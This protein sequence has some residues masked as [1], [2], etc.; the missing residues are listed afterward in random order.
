MVPFDWLCFIVHD[1]V[2]PFTPNKTNVAHCNLLW[3][4]PKFPLKQSRNEAINRNKMCH[5]PCFRLTLKKYHWI[6]T[7][8]AL[9]GRVSAWK[10]L[11]AFHYYIRVT[12]T[13]K[14]WVHLAIRETAVEEIRS[15]PGMEGDIKFNYAWE[16]LVLSTSLSTNASF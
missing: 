4:V 6:N 5:E 15:W 8:A 9:T 10:A 11:P 1:S 14:L 12:A 13:V 2:M 3:N 7:A 16:Y